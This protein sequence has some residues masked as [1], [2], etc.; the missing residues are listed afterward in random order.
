MCRYGPLDKITVQR[1]DLQLFNALA[2]VTSKLKIVVLLALIGGWVI[3][4]QAQQDYDNQT[5]QRLRVIQSIDRSAQR[6]EI[7]PET[8]LLHK[9]YTAFN[10]HK[11]ADSLSRK[12][13]LSENRKH[14]HLKCVTPLV[15]EYHVQRSGLSKSATDEIETM[16]AGEGATDQSYLS[17][18]GRFEIFYTTT[19]SS[20]VPTADSDNSG[21][22]DYVELAAE[23]ADSSY[24][25]EVTRLGYRDFLPSSGPYEILLTDTGNGIYGFTETTA[26]GTRFSVH[27]NFEGFPSNTDPD[28]DQAGALKVT[29]AH[30]MKHSIQFV[31]NR[32]QGESIRWAEMDATMMEDVVYDVVNDYYNYINGFES[33][34]TNPERSFSPGSYEDVS[35]ALYFH[36]RYGDRFWVDVW[37]EIIANGSTMPT[38]VASVIPQYNPESSYSEEVHEAFRW[39]NAAG[40]DSR[41]TFGFEDKLLYPDL[42]PLQRY[43]SVSAAANLT[44]PSLSIHSAH[45]FNVEP[46]T[47][48]RGPALVAIFKDDSEVAFGWQGFT[49]EL[50]MNDGLERSS[51]IGLYDTGQRWEDLQKLSVVVSN[52]SVSQRLNYTLLIGN[53]STIQQLTYGDQDRDNG[54]S[55]TDGQLIADQSVQPADRVTSLSRFTGDVSGDRTLSA[56]DASLVLKAEANSSRTFPVDTDGNGLGPEPSMFGSGGMELVKQQSDPPQAFFTLQPQQKIAADDDSTFFSVTLEPHGSMTVSSVMLAVTFDPTQYRFEAISKNRMDWQEPITAARV[57]EGGDRDTVFVAIASAASRASGAIATIKFLN[58]VANPSDPFAIAASQLDEQQENHSVSDNQLILSNDQ[59]AGAS[60]P[61]QVT[62]HQ[63]YPNPF[64]PSTTI[65]FALPR[66]TSVTL[67]LFDVTGRE[68]QQLVS[69]TRYSRGIHRIAFDGSSLA[70]GVYFYRLETAE[71]VQTVRSMMLIK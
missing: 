18:S 51:R 35:F 23:A 67:R 57:A 45:V 60:I 14:D 26:N 41:G 32:W 58:Q 37:R 17:P 61:S 24:R 43:T 54:L 63:N 7:R 34:F 69:G 68:V 2:N 6:G 11:L 38:A 40:G 48:E 10:P 22:P 50:L 1:C 70:S 56:Y 13:Q 64:N 59:P 12:L 28:G 15:M 33:L 16:L 5:H 62:L 55:S 29:I 52:A 4:L 44:E 20:A 19:G 47:G 49:S 36:E 65:S 25:H 30:E 42:D 53:E 21:I 66:A 3:P 8:A 9:F 71:G 31:A 46:S 39:H 27:H